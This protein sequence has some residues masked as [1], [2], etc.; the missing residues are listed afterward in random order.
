LA[1]NSSNFDGDPQS[2]RP[3]RR[4]G[5]MAHLV[6][7]AISWGIAGTTLLALILLWLQKRSGMELD[8]EQYRGFML[9]I[10]LINTL[11]AY[12]LL[13]YFQHR[14]NQARARA[15][16]AAPRRRPQ[17]VPAQP[18]FTPIFVEPEK[19]AE[20]QEPA[21]PP[22]PAVQAF[23]A[24]P[25]AQPET[26]YANAIPQKH[27][28]SAALFT[29]AVS[30][31]AAGMDEE[32]NLFMQFGIHLFVMGGCG[33]MTR[34]KALPAD[35]GKS[36]LIQM[37]GELGMAPRAAAAF[38]AN[39]NTFAQVPNFRGIIDAGYAAMANLQEAGFVNIAD[40]LDATAQWK[41]QEGICQPPEPMT[42]MTTSVGVVPPGTPVT[43]EDRSRI[44][45]AHN[46]CIGEILERCQGRE[47]HN[48]GNG[49]VAAFTDASLAGA[50][51]T[52]RT[53]EPDADCRTA[54][55]HRYGNGRDGEWEL[56]IDGP[57]ARR[58]HC[59]D[60]ARAG[61]LLQRSH[62]G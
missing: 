51:G 14:E 54:R 33:E 18:A 49:V 32:P 24:P 9:M 59:R 2:A 34:R 52:L 53:R 30:A 1:E 55:R 41:V 20:P 61:N 23:A 7:T 21:P 35:Q 22:E 45:R 5:R 25:T 36:L 10:F 46:M 44:L 43:P 39:A 12:V 48:L 11:S 6:T 56:R 42:F 31:A 47:I 19:P 28:A 4:F 13:E 3:R 57:D 26:A 37:M 50:F 16:K 60:H 15:A 62:Q 8:G 38:A 58:Q 40:F 17:P 27:D 29:Q